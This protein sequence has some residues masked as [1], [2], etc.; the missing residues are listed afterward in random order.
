MPRT[1]EE[2]LK[3]LQSRL[4]G[5]VLISRSDLVL[6]DIIAA[7]MA[8]IERRSKG[9]EISNLIEDDKIKVRKND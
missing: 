9:D 5:R 6:L 1:R 8:E 4:A 2:I 3:S 7:E